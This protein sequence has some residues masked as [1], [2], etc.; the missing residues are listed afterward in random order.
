MD[1]LLHGGRPTAWATER[2]GEGSAALRTISGLAVPTITGALIEQQVLALPA[3]KEVS[4]RISDMAPRSLTGYT[5]SIG[6]GP[7]R[8]F[9]K[10]FVDGSGRGYHARFEGEFLHLHWDRVCYLKDPLGHG[11]ADAPEVLVAGGVWAYLLVLA[12][13]KR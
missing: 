5:E 8:H 12:L 2:F 4:V 11:L 1:S 7:G 13:R 10:S 3:H 6:L 9:R